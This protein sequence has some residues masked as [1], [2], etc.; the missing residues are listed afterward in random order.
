MRTARL[1][2][3]LCLRLMRLRSLSL[4]I[5]NFIAFHIVLCATTSIGT[6]V[7]ARNLDADIQEALVPTSVPITAPAITQTTQDLVNQRQIS[8]EVEDDIPQE[9]PG[10]GHDIKLTTEYGTYEQLLSNNTPE[11]DVIALC[12]KAEEISVIKG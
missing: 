5:N 11:R 4:W 2:S 10:N 7:F 6:G 3:G 8:T 1:P 9:L 12:S